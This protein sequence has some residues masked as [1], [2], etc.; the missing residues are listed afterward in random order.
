MT[1]PGEPRVHVCALY[2]VG[3]RMFSCE[4]GV[5]FVPERLIVEGV[6]RETMVRSFRIRCGDRT[7]ELLLAP[8]LAS[9]F[10]AMSTVARKMLVPVDERAVVI[11]APGDQLELELDCDEPQAQC[12]VMGRSEDA[13]GGVLELDAELQGRSK[14]P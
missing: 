5:S 12:A 1:S 14:P 8:R 9:F 4:V 7:V 3:S 6:S 11:M 10:S 2:A 13:A